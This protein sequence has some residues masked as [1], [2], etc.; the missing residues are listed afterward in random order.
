MRGFFGIYSFL[1]NILHA[2]L[3]NSRK[4]AKKRSF[5]NKYY[6]KSGKSSTY[7]GMNA[8]VHVTYSIINAGIRQA[9]CK[10]ILPAFSISYNLHRKVT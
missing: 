6:T 9:S 1:A 10:K 3:R 2:A 4:K 8:F 7:F 5:Q